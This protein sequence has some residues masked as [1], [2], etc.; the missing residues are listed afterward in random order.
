MAVAG[1]LAVVAIAVAKSA[2]VGIGRA[3]VHGHKE[4]VAVNAKGV[5]IYELG[6]E[7][8][9]HL[10]CK[11][12]TCFAAWPPVKAKGAVTKMAGVTGKLGTIKRDGFTQV[13][14]DGKPVYTFVEDGGRR[15]E[16]EGDG[17][18]NFGGIW[19]VFKES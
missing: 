7:T 2:T 10:V 12:Q 14:L 18:R 9:R 19:H 5:T 3:S 4:S 1:L 11:S 15:G 16:A 6:P 17:I 8:S 13:T